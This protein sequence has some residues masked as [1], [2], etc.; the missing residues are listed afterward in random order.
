MTDPSLISL[1]TNPLG[2]T[3]DN[4]ADEIDTQPSLLTFVGE[5]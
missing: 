2:L 1:N 3:E 5:P 4:F